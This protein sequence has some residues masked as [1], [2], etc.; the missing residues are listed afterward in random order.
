MS[1]ICFDCLNEIFGGKENPKKYVMSDY[2]ELC[3]HCGKYKKVVVVKR[4]I[5]YYIY[6]F[7]FI[8]YPLM[9]VCFPLM[10]LVAVVIRLYWKL[11]IKN[12]KDSK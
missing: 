9:V 3:E 11:K 12:F 1:E 4:N 6:R 10:L 5:H 7:R 8:I 2:S